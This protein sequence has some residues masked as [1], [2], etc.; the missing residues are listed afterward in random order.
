MGADERDLLARITTQIENCSRV[1]HRLARRRAVLRDA[2]TMLRLGRQSAVA[3][4]SIQEQAPDAVI[5]VQQ[6][7]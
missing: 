2:A 1:E 5:T 7:A 6:E 4:A 3:L